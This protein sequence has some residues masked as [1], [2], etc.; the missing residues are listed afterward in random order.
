MLGRIAPTPPW[1]FDAP[2]G[3]RRR[4]TGD[5]AILDEQCATVSAV[6][7]LLAHRRDAGEIEQQRALRIAEI[8][9][10]YASLRGQVGIEVLHHRAIRAPRVEIRQPDRRIQTP[11]ERDARGPVEKRAPVAAPRR[12]YERNPQQRQENR[13]E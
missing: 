13:G 5:R 2:T 11:R 9:A 7:R 1:P 12:T 4:R 10:R 3:K 8:A 6:V